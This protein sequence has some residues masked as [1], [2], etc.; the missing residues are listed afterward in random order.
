MGRH[1]KFQKG[2]VI[3]E[4]LVAF[5]LASI[6]LPAILAG[7]ISGSSGK[8][9]Q[10]QRLIAIGYLEEGAEAVRSVRESAWGNIS[11]NNTGRT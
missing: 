3:V 5:G 8:V 1:T 10:Q 11:G 9:Q 4:L 6:L 7:F 2:Q